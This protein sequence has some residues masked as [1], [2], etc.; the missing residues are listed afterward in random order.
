MDVP[1]LSVPSSAFG[2]STAVPDETGMSAP[3]GFHRED[4]KDPRSAVSTKSVTAV[5]NLSG[6]VSFVF[7]P[8]GGGQVRRAVFAPIAALAP[9]PTV[10]M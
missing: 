4:K 9:H 10:A 3:V 5:V 1:V 7:L 6:G 2:H 8:G